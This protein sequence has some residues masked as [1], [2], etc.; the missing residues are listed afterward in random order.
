MRKTDANLCQYAIRILTTYL[1]L[2]QDFAN[3]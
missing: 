3:F 1:L 2:G